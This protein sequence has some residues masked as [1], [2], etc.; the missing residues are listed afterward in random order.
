MTCMGGNCEVGDGTFD[1][2]TDEDSLEDAD[3]PDVD[4][5]GDEMKCTAYS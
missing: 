1:D 5:E 4:D 2:E 3:S